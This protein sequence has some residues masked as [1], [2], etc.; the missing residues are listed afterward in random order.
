MAQQG[1]EDRGFY[2]ELRPEAGLLIG[3]LTC[4]LLPI[5]GN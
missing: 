2:G 5:N 3:A 1:D 4:A